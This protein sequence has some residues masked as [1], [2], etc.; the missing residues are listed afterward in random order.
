M[1][2]MINSN[3]CFKSLELIYQNNLWDLI[4]ELPKSSNILFKY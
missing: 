4:F 1:N 3:S 2:L